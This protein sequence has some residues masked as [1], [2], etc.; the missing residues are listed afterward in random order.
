MVAVITLNLSWTIVAPHAVRTVARNIQQT[1]RAFFSTT[2]PVLL[3]LQL[4]FFTVLIIVL[5]VL[6][7]VF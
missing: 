6:I 4:P 5:I 3:S 7:I 2:A 1:L